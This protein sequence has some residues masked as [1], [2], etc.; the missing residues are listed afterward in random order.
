MK[1]LLAFVLLGFALACTL[2]S[3]TFAA[4]IDFTPIVETG[5][6]VLNAVIVAAVGVLVPFALKKLKLDGIVADARMNEML[7]AGIQR[8][9]DSLEGVARERIYKGGTTATLDVNSSVVASVANRMIE[10]SPELLK[11]IGISEATLRQLVAEK[12]QATISKPV[13][14]VAPTAVVVSPGAI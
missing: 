12:L 6:W 2:I 11:R 3:P 8:G 10:L 4:E 9:I 5:F 14:V 1:N 7:H 13:A